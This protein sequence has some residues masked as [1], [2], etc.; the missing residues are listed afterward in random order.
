MPKP[1]EPAFAERAAR[2][3]NENRHA[4]MDLG[5][6]LQ[7]G[8]RILQM[9]R[10]VIRAVSRDEE[11]ILPAMLFFAVAGFASG[12]GQFSFR[13]M[14]LGSLMVTLVS[15][16]TIGLLHVLARL[17]GSTATFLELY[18]PLGLAAFIHWVQVFPFIGPFLGFL[19]VLFSLVV[20][21]VVLETVGGL[22]RSKALVVVTLLFGILVFLGLVFLA[23]LGSLLLLSA[24]L[25]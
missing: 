4:Q 9:D 24:V 6:Y 14:L 3:D 15:F 8:L 23:I 19:A 22:A 17:F 1:F 13:A 7:E 11:A 25:A 20:A 10:D 5:A 2:V 12:L 18:R 16:V 21:V